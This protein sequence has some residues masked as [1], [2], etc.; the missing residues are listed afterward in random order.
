MAASTGVEFGTYLGEAILEPLGLHHTEFRASAA[1]GMSSTVRD[2]TA[3]VREII[4]SGVAPDAMSEISVSVLPPH[5][6]MID[7]DVVAGDRAS[8][9]TSLQYCMAVAAVAPQL[10]FDVQQSPPELPLAVRS[11]MAKIKVEAGTLDRI[12][13]VDEVAR[14][15]EVFAGPLGA[16]VSGQVLRIDGGGQCWPG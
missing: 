16:F 11:F 14:V 15:V 7:H 1:H 6:K 2:L 4:E 13:T 5:L 10:A 12:A 3:F 9:L 8:H